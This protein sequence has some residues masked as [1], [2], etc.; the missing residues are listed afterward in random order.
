MS[1]TVSGCGDD[2]VADDA[3]D[4]V[5]HGEE[6]PTKIGSTG[7]ADNDDHTPS[8][9]GVSMSLIPSGE[10]VR[11]TPDR[12]SST[13]REESISCGGLEAPS[14]GDIETEGRESSSGVV[15]MDR[16]RLGEGDPTRRTKSRPGRLDDPAYSSSSGVAEPRLA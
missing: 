14:E 5:A 1:G 6:F 15:G 13:D 16:H 9:E 2:E 4:E 11:E 10:E 12:S 8:S 7:E 3:Y